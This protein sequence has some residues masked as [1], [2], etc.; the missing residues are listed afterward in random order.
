MHAPVDDEGGRV[1][2]LSG[3]FPARARRWAGALAARPAWAPLALAALAGVAA[4]TL[5]ST[6]GVAGL[7]VAAL[8][9][10]PCG[11]AAVAL[12][13]QAPV[14]LASAGVALAAGYGVVVFH[15]PEVTLFEVAAV[16][17]SL[18]LIASSSGELLA[19]A[20]NEPALR[21]FLA[22]S[23]GLLLL[24]VL[25]SLWSPTGLGLGVPRKELGKNAEIVA[26][27]LA[28]LA[29]VDRPAR[30]AR[31]Y[32]LL[33]A[34]VFVSAVKPVLTHGGEVLATDSLQ[35]EAPLVFLVLALPFASRLPVT[36]L[37]GT[38]GVLLVVARTRGGWVAA[39]AV[40]AL[41]LGQRGLR[42]SVGR[43]AAAVLGVGTVLLVAAVLLLPSVR[44][45]LDAL[46][47]GHDQSVDTRLSMLHAAEL[48]LQ[49]HPLTGVGPGNFKTW[50][51][52]NGSP[53]DFRIGVTVIPRDPHDTFAKFAAEMGA[54]GLLLH[55]AWVAAVLAAPWLA[56]R[57]A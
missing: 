45:R 5:G 47:S 54:P 35:T 16:L 41:V 50:L 19:A 44:G 37:I 24:G 11:V 28:V 57:R 49:G 3:L 26:L 4:G 53:V 36:A 34:L 29:Y 15:S 31:A 30:L 51:L 40:A 38:G 2:G 46:V 33:A 8:V 6:Q 1:L 17:P 42:G 22:A 52:A 56:L 9:V 12:L 25:Y 21:L 7:L 32:V 48:E 55:L 20:R 10:L 39:V 14:S 18:Y 43:A 13:A 23:L 27:A